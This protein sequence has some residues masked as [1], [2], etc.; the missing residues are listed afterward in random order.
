MIS[1]ETYIMDTEIISDERLYHR[2]LTNMPAYRQEKIRS[3]IFEKDRLLSL[4]AGALLA[5]SLGS[6]GISEHRDIQL[7]DNG[8]PYLSSRLHYNISHSG[9]KIVCSFS[10]QEVGVDLEQI[11][12]VDDSLIRQVCVASEQAHL[13]QLEPEAQGREFFVLWTAKESY[14]KLRGTGLALPPKQLE[15]IFGDPL[16]IRDAGTSS[17][18][19]FRRY[20]LENYCLTVCSEHADFADSLISIDNPDELKAIFS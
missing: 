17:N 16:R 19:Q 20:P 3:Y 15:L 1:I 5:Y 4:G 11:L 8:K 9:S 18:V 13:L 7:G 14:M 12:P 2:L 6:R 10:E